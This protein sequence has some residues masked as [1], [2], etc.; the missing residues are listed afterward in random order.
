MR[1]PLKDYLQE[2]QKDLLAG[3]ATEHTHRPTLKALLEALEPGVRATNEPK[4]ITDCGKP[5]LTASRGPAL[6]GYL[7]TKDVGLDLAKEEKSQQLTRYRGGLPNLVLTDY[8][9]FRWYVNGEPRGRAASLGEF[10]PDR[11]IKVDKAGLAAVRELLG[12]FLAHESPA[13]GTA[14]ELALR[15]AGLAKIMRAAALKTLEREPHTGALK[16]WLAEFEE[17]LIK[18]I[19]PLDFAD[20]YA[21]T[22]TYG[23]FAAKVTVGTAQNLTPETAA[24]L[25]PETN[26]FLKKLFYH[27]AG[28]EVP[29]SV[30]WV[31]NDLIAALN[32]TAWEEVLKDF[33]KGSLERDPV[34]H[35]YETFL[36]HY[37]PEKRERRGVYYTPEPVVSFIVRAI[38]Y[39]LRE[40]FGRALGL[41]DPHTLVL[42]PACGTGTFLHSVITLIYDTLSALGQSGTWNAYVA[43]HL[44]PRLFGFELLMAPYAVAHL[45]LALLLKEKGYIFG[46][47]QRLGV[48]LTN[49][50]D[51]GFKPSKARVLAGYITEE[52]NTATRIKQ[53]DPIE[54]ILGN[55]PYSA[56]SANASLIREVDSKTRKVKISRTW[57]GQLIEDYK[58]VDG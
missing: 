7:E 12:Q 29:P 47:G 50:L 28:P 41:A 51:E 52:T 34:V 36:A 44:L 57:I 32:N 3:D 4:Q 45:K 20:M 33:G 17:N 56:H 55:P 37:A 1:E 26:P 58:Q 5:D 24:S 49:T 31:I 23:L 43:D 42:D 38:D 15:M 19:T 54:V 40:R 14:K 9:E 30:S 10:R 22:L 27:L 25:L 53:E 39:L 16:G 18:N 48:Y 46:S 13:I 35:F 2:L 21:Q 8:L 6:L 11:G